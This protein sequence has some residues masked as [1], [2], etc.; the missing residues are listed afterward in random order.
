MQKYVS[1]AI[2]LLSYT[3]Q[4]TLNYYLYSWSKTSG[5]KCT[6]FLILF[7][8]F[9]YNRHIDGT[10]KIL[11]FYPNKNNLVV[12]HCFSIYRQS[13]LW[14]TLIDFLN[15]YFY[16]FL[17]HKLLIY[18]IIFWMT[19]KCLVIRR[20]CFKPVLK[21]YFSPYQF[22]VSQRINIYKPIN[23]NSKQIGTYHQYI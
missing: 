14:K 6:Q 1:Q 22:I 2:N 21:A 11:T 17:F 10:Q 16:C 18:K 15:L 8:Q 3:V 4:N 9:K 7:F 23:C 20:G 5:A 12:Y 19:K 13:N